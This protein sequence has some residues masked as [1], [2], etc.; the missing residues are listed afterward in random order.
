[1]ENN[2]IMDLAK[3]LHEKHL[4]ASMTDAIKKA[5]DILQ[6]SKNVAQKHAEYRDENKV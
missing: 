3:N 1:M 6:G 5:K 4:A 2:E